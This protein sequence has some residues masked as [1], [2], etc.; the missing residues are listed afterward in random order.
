MSY[1]ALGL[2][3]PLSLFIPKNANQVIKDIL[4]SLDPEG[5]IL[6]IRMEGINWNEAN[7]AAEKLMASDSS[8]RFIHPF[9]AESVWE[10]NSTIVDEIKDQLAELGEE[11]DPSG[12]AT[13]VGGGGLAAGIVLGMQRHGWTETALIAM[14]TT[15]ANCFNE[16]LKANKLVKLDAIRSIASSLGALEVTE[17]LLKQNQEHPI[18][19]RVITDKQALQA[20]LDFASDHRILVEPACG[21]SLCSVYNFD[22]LDFS[23][24][25]D[26]SKP[27]VIVVCGGNQAT[28]ELFEKWKNQFG[29]NWKMA[30]FL[31]L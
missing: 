20:C 15:G 14:E 25:L 12:I 28:F 3:T 6:D 27:L 4:A 19:S 21:A 30:Y 31:Q 29:M 22:S 10:G 13:C 26:S 7:E 11:S 2:K 8:A 5:D 9:D 24:R 23:E 1:A 18:I 17:K 16:A